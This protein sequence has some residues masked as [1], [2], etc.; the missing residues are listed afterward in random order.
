MWLD[1]KGACRK[2]VGKVG[3]KR[4]KGSSQKAFKKKKY[5]ELCKA[6]RMCAG[7]LRSTSTKVV[8][9][10]LGVS[11]DLREGQHMLTY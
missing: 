7:T 6:N 8:R 10:E 4:E 3:M 9:F 5:R 11:F 2:H 1:Q